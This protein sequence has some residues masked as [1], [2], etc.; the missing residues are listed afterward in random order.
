[1]NLITFDDLV[2]IC[3]VGLWPAHTQPG[4]FAP[5]REPR[6]EPWTVVFFVAF[7]GATTFA[8]PLTA[9]VAARSF[10]WGRC[11]FPCPDVSLR[12]LISSAIAFSGLAFFVRTRALWMARVA[13]NVVV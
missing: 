12:R 11:D 2:D 1:M 7:M 9:N 8:P 5:R 3:K 13:A 4:R 10:F 6:Q